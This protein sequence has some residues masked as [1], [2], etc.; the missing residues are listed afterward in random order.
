MV[1]EFNPPLSISVPFH[2][3]FKLH[4]CTVYLKLQVQGR[5]RGQSKYMRSQRGI[6]LKASS[7]EV[8]ILIDYKGTNPCSINRGSAGK[9]RVIQVTGKLQFVTLQ[10]I[11]ILDNYNFFISASTFLYISITLH[12]N[13]SNAFCWTHPYGSTN[14]R[15][16]LH[17]SL[18]IL[19]QGLSFFRIFSIATIFKVDRLTHPSSEVYQCITS[20]TC[21]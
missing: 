19:K 10:D 12:L 8:V 7:T 2:M 21:F 20:I 6:E 4:W 9:Y 13:Q 3:Y 16:F 11:I 18:H 15:L 5:Q 1:H 17:W 14:E